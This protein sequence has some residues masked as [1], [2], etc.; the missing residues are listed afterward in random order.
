MHSILNDIVEKCRKLKI[1]GE[2]EV[3]E[4]SCELIFSM[5]ERS[6]LNVLFEG[7]FGPPIKPTGKTPAWRDRAMTRKDKGIRPEQ[8]LF[9]KGFDGRTAIAIVKP[10]DRGTHI[11]VRLAVLDEPIYVVTRS[12][13]SRFINIFFGE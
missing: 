2:R 11:T 4:R 13:L 10:W 3:T 6:E 8:K 7:I 1:Q 9:A 5:S 12:P